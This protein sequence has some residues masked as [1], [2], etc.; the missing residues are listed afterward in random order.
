MDPAEHA[1]NMVR[2]L[3]RAKASLFPPQ[4]EQLHLNINNLN[5]PAEVVPDKDIS[6][7]DQDYIVVSGQIDQAL[8]ERIIPGE[9]VDFSKLLPK[10]RVSTL[11]DDK[12]E[13][14]VHN[15]KAFWAPVSEP[16][17]INNFSKWEQAFRVYANIKANIKC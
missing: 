12:L 17:S 14:V 8:Q 3:E 10:D 1:A 15:G 5:V 6:L 2:L 7:M 4:G 13:L 11:D 9:Y 16:M